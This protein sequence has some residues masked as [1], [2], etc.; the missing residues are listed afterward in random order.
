MATK[1]MKNGRGY[2][3]KAFFAALL[4]IVLQAA[5]A[6]LLY[7]NS[8]SVIAAQYA[9]SAKAAAE[10]GADILGGRLAANL[11]D[12]DRFE[13]EEYIKGKYRISGVFESGMI[14]SG[15]NTFSPSA[16]VKQN[17]EGRSFSFH[18]LAEI[19]GGDGDGIYI[20]YSKNDG[21]ALRVLVQS[22]E[23]F[24]GGFKTSLF[25]RFVVADGKGK[26]LLGEGAGARLSDLVQGDVL[27]AISEETTSAD[28]TAAGED[29]LLVITPIFLEEG[30]PRLYAAGYLF[31][32]DITALTEQTNQ[33]NMIILGF[34]S[35]GVI[36]LMI[37]F[38]AASVRQRDYLNEF[39]LKTRDKYVLLVD[40]MGRIRRANKVFSE[41]FADCNV[42]DNMVFFDAGKSVA[43]GDSVIVYAFNKANEKRL[44]NFFVAKT[45]RGFKLVGVDATN[46]LENSNTN[47]FAHTILSLKDMEGQFG[48]DKLTN[49]KL[50]LGTVDITNLKNLDLMFGRTFSEQV[51]ETVGRRVR[52]RFGKVYEMPGGRMGVLVSDA[53]EVDF[54]V[55]DLTAI[56]DGFGQSVLVDENLVN[57]NCK[58]GFAICDQTNEDDSFGY[59]LN[60]ANAALKRAR[61]EERISYFVYHESQKKLYQKLMDKNW[62]IKAMLAAN[63]F[64]MGFQPQFYLDGDKPYG[65]EALFRVKKALSMEVDIFELITY[66][67]RT[68]NMILLGEFIF[69]EG[70]KFAK[71]IEGSGVHVSLNVSPVQLMQAGFVESFLKIYN[72]HNLKPNSISIEITES[73]LMTNFD[74]TLA[75]LQLLEKNGIDIHLDDFGVSYSSMLYLKK[76]PISAIKIDRE[77]IADI[78][79]NLYSR[80]ITKTIIDITKQLGQICISEGVETQ[81]QKD[82]LKS[83]G[84][85]VIQGFLMGRAVPAEEARRLLF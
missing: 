78:E 2:F 23:S 18:T 3:A 52:K 29:A 84:C 79:K 45:A 26:I 73:F 82:I 81:G 21:G 58:A 72:K 14:V 62:D 17:I 36:I 30:E 27:G 35:L 61:K 38:F 57:V 77:F 44:I 20:I 19:T 65:F 76:L 31:K 50:L 8:S 43:D 66:A 10:S 80:T 40:P 12:F 48:R 37:M 24:L 1:Q 33:K 47:I 41:T 6:M 4:L 9:L 28:V 25:E 85:D 39:G 51:F 49:K 34:S 59:V 75:K 46:V 42:F 74:E 70:M 16:T 56:M 60:C 55:K 64:E 5:T 32:S 68:G 83:L 69:N 22:Q 13:D 15:E 63:S 7:A 53:K 54:T 11:G 71:S 67:E